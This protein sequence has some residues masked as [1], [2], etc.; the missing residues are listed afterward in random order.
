[1]PRLLL[2]LLLIAVCVYFWSVF[3][4]RVFSHRSSQGPKTADP[5]VDLVRD[6]NCL[7]LVPQKDALKITRSGA[8]HYFC[9]PECAEAFEKKRAGKSN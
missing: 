3:L 9:G 2:I 7:T 6:P 8:T 4:R 5:G 1:M